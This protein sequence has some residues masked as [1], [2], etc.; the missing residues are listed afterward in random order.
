[1]VTDRDLLK[2]R[3]REARIALRYARCTCGNQ[4]HDPFWVRCAKTTAQI[5]FDDALAALRGDP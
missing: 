1:M 5:A 4:N 3:V 2:R